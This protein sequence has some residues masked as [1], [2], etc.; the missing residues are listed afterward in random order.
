MERRR[1]RLGGWLSTADPLIVEAV[2]RAGYDW[3]GIDLQ[4]GAWDVGTAA[5]GIQLLDLLNVPVLVRVADEELSL[6]PHVLDQGAA[7]IIIAMA[8]SPETVATAIARARYHPEGQR[9]YGGQR[10]GMRHEPD[11]ITT[12]RPAVYA[13]LETRAAVECVAEIVAVPG[14]AGVH[15]GPVDLRLSIGVAKAVASPAF[16]RALKKIVQT[17]H[18]AGVPA[19]MH[20]VAQSQVSE[21]IELG[22]DELVLSAEIRLLRQALADEIANARN[23]I[24]DAA[25]GNAR[26]RPRFAPER[27][28]PSQTE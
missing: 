10:Y 25:G 17:S 20:A 23:Q 18:A 12:I 14:I 5:R 27:P 9:S 26:K 11:D 8:S 28:Q 1:I 3:V 16:E 4:H 7:G 19:V 2:G 22:F 6:I 24:E 15:I 13:M 21:M